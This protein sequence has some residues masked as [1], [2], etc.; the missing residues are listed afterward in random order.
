M[1]K[2][3]IHILALLGI[4][5]VH[6][7]SKGLP[8]RRDFARAQTPPMGWNSYNHYSCSPNQEIM[9]SNAQALVDLGLAGYHYVTTD[10]GWTL[11]DRTKEGK[12]TWNPDRFPDGLPALGKFIHG[13]GLRFGVYSDAGVKMCM[14]GSL[15]HEATDAET[16]A[17]WEADL[18]KY[19]NCFSSA[20][21]NFP[22][23]DFA[24][25]QP[26]RVRFEAMRKAL[27]ATGR[28]IIYSICEWG[29][30]FPSA[31]APSLG[32]SWRIT[33]DIQP[34]WSSI[35]RILNQFVPSASFAGPGRWPDLDMLEVGNEIFTEAE[36]QTHFSLWA[37]AKSPLFI[38]GRLKDGSGEI[39]KSSLAI[40]S[41]E[42][43]IYFNQDSLGKAA[44]LMR[45]Y[46]MAG[47]DVW[48]GPLS[49]GRTV[50]ALI[51]WNN[52][53]VDATLNLPDVGLQSAGTVFDVWANKPVKDVK[54]SY[55]A[56]VAA[57]GTLLLELGDTAPAGTYSAALFGST[58]GDSIVF[59]GIYGLTDSAEYTVEI[60]TD[61]GAPAPAFTITTSA[62]AGPGKGGPGK[63]GP[64]KGG[65][66]VQHVTLKAANDN[67]ITISPAAKILSIT[68]TPPAGTFYPSTDFT[69]SGGAK[70]FP[71]DP[72]LCAPVGAKIVDVSSSSSATISI[73]AANSPDV[74]S[75][76]VEIT[77][78][79]NEVA[80]PTGTNSRSLTI[81]VNGAEPVRLE[82]PL[83]GR[84]SELYSPIHGWGD[85]AVL[86]ML[87]PGFKGGPGKDEIVVS[88]VG[89]E[90]GVQRLG[91]D[92]VGLK[93]F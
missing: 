22:E 44:N 54:T 73:P 75:R 88:N 43:V 27:D 37:I 4:A 91:P 40:L 13:L 70:H 58:K 28:D 41:N 23:T 29:V 93:V 10:C 1:A 47:L 52:E 30:D 92:L 79:N 53:A 32:Q 46:T 63:G 78:I 50:A 17:A 33:N 31:W 67:T 38:G 24:P 72:G 48:A 35:W 61:G 9:K 55:S 84:S 5:A 82:V 69:P 26:P 19:D 86:G 90:A 7:T 39:S 71:C 87:V 77:Y 25:S 65:P 11:P 18:L 68:V 66:E 42:R 83:S 34:N 12:L 3:S 64:G 15:D 76:Y 59:S 36:E 85:S 51:N 14:I 57:H 45:R 81:A 80:L 8:E 16:F 21:K 20:D 62:K 56:R 89:G 74:G 60:H 2:A 6:A 49:G